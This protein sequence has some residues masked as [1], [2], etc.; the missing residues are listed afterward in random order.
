MRNVR[1]YTIC[2][3]GEMMDKNKS[4]GGIGFAGVLTII[5]VIAKLFGVINWS[6][7]LVFTPMLIS[8]GISVLILGILGIL[9]LVDYKNGNL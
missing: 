7:W 1:Q 3:G 4:S 2:E 6:W 5:F 9:A 8:L